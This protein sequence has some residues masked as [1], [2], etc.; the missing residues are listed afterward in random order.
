MP[1]TKKPASRSSR[2]ARPSRSSAASRASAAFPEPAALKR[3][4]KSIDTAADALAALRTNTKANHT[5]DAR[6]LYKDLRTF[7]ES[8]RRSAGKLTTTLQSDFEQAQKLLSA[9]RP[10]A[11]PV[12]KAA[13]KAAAKVTGKPARKPAGKA[14]AKPASKTTSKSS[15]PR[16]S[17]TATK[18][19]A[20]TTSAR[21]RASAPKAKA[22]KG[23][24]SR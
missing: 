24:A 22:S 11:K 5:R 6:E 10:Q 8:A 18:A 14:A 19:K 7:L 20:S 4:A 23:T 2:A 13:G 21:T 12:R 3:L 9:N 16:S 1:P 15:S 17:S